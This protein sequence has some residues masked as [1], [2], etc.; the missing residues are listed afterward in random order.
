MLLKR[1]L[2]NKEFSVAV[3]HAFNVLCF[4]AFSVSDGLC[5]MCVSGA[6]SEVIFKTT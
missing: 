1:K 4:G 2:K 6:M 5:V 3:L